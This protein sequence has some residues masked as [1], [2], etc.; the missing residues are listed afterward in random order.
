LKLPPEEKHVTE[1]VAA[2]LPAPQ[3]YSDYKKTLSESA[4]EVHPSSIGQNKE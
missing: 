4:Y 1:K 3:D 2:L